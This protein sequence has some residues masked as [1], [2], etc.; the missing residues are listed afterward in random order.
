MSASPPRILSVVERLELLLLARR[1][2]ESLFAREQT[3]CSKRLMISGEFG[4]AFVTFWL[5]NALRGCVGSFVSTHDVASTVAEVTRASLADPRFRSRPITGAELPELA[6]EISVPSALEPCP[7]PLSLVPG[8]HGIVIRQGRLSGCFLPRVASEHGWSPEEFLS[9]CCTL[10][11][12]L[13]PDAWRLGDTR[14]FWFTAEVFSEPAFPAKH[15]QTEASI[16]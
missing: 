12:G 2:A 10:K 7:D 9:K 15:S 6:I 14:V 1:S 4:G 11:A 5:Q 8:L 13:A 16:G 3:L